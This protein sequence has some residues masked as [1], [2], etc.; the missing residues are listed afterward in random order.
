MTSHA[1]KCVDKYCE[2]TG[3][4][5]NALLVAVTHCMDD[6]LSSEDFEVRRALH[7]SCAKIVLKCFLFATRWWTSFVLDNDNH[8]RE[9]HRTPVDITHAAV[10]HSRTSVRI[11][12]KLM[13]KQFESHCHWSSSMARTGTSWMWSSCWKS[14]TCWRRSCVPKCRRPERPAK[15]GARSKWFLSG[16]LR[17]QEPDTTRT[18]HVLENNR[19]WKKFCKTCL[20]AF[21]SLLND[22]PLK[23][24]VERN[25][26]ISAQHTLEMTENCIMHHEK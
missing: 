21:A 13:F 3:K 7:E 8:Q 2:R 19:L 14:T 5:V 9:I 15:S 10:W 11:P 6:Q 4:N 20:E 22:E 18:Q 26:H 23:I 24:V 17:N 12:C 1:G 25:D 16:C